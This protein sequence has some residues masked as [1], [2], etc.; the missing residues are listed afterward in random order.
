MSIPRRYIVKH[1]VFNQILLILALSF[2]FTSLAQSTKPLV[3][4][5]NASFTAQTF[6]DRS[7]EGNLASYRIG[8]FARIGVTVTKPAYVYLFSVRDNL[9]VQ[10]LP[11]RFDSKNYLQAG[12]T[13][14]FPAQGASYNLQVT[15]PPGIEKVF[16]VASQTPLDISTA[17]SAVE[18]GGF[19]TYSVGLEAFGAKMLQVVQ[20]TP[21]PNWVTANVDLQVLP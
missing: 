9:T 12:E 17:I 14:Y 16:V 2:C 20:S 1:S 13:R 11:N 7:P 19:E 21:K 3:I 8:E 18:V 4:N 5:P 6:L 10:L 15:G